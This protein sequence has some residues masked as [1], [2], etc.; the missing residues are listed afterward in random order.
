[1]FVIDCSPLTMESNMSSKIKD[2]IS[3]FTVKHISNI[4]NKATE[5]A[6]DA[7]YQISTL[8]H[9]MSR[10]DTTLKALSNCVN[11][12]MYT[13]L[14]PL[15]KSKIKTMVMNLQSHSQ[16]ILD[17]HNQVQQ[18]INETESLF[19]VMTILN[20]FDI[21]ENKKILS[22]RISEL[23]EIIKIQRKYKNELKGGLSIKNSLNEILTEHNN[24]TDDIEATSNKIEDLLTKSTNTNKAI[25]DALEE[26]NKVLDSIKTN[27]TT[28]SDAIKE[29]TENLADINS[30]KE[31]IENFNKD[32]ETYKETINSTEELSSH[33]INDNNSKFAE[34]LKNIKTLESNIKDLLTKA[35]GISLFQ[36]FENRKDKLWWSKAFW[37]LSIIGMMILTYLWTL[38]LSSPTIINGGQAVAG[39]VPNSINTLFYIKLS[40]VF[41][42]AYLFVFCTKQY[43][44]ERKLEEEYAF[45]SNI[46]LS[47]EPYREFI[48]GFIDMEKDGEKEKYTQFIIDS[49][50]KIFISPTDNLINSKTEN[51]EDEK[52]IGSLESSIKLIKDLKDIVK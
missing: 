29:A 40:L 25:G 49:L 33:T 11:K 21:P 39:E 5:I 43:T 45:K 14:P 37:F 44:L 19:E 24:S 52:S 32:I 30:I 16:N 18:L 6:P 48:E 1:M 10:L 20:L 17:G 3:T 36:S 34:Q 22:K 13:N 15:T 41:P 47:L 8:E 42:I 2:I 9:S 26:S 50:E 28:G 31:T 35:T 12:G 27:N 38:W 23:N 4:E 7:S 46:S 51:P